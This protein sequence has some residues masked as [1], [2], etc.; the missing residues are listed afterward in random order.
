MEGQRG[1]VF[2]FFFKQEGEFGNLPNSAFL[3]SNKVPLV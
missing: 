2:F 3:L 1:F